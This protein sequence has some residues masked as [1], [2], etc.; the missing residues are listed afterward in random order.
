[1][2][3]CLTLGCILFLPEQIVRV[4]GMLRGSDPPEREPAVCINHREMRK[5]HRLSQADL[6]RFLGTSQTMYS[7]YERGENEIPVHHLIRLR[8]LYHVSAD[9]LLGCVPLPE[10]LPVTKDE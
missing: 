5:K 7:R 1:M 2:D 10:D 3:I 8:D 6:A 4:P 9:A